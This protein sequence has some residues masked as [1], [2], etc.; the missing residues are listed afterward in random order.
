MVSQ[1]LELSDPVMSLLTN[2][3]STAAGGSLLLLPVHVDV[4]GVGQYREAHLIIPKELRH[5]DVPAEFV[6][7]GG[8]RIGLS[9]YSSEDLVVAFAF[10]VVQN[11]TW[12]AAKTA[13]SYLFARAR[14][15]ATDTEPLMEMKIAR[16]SRPDGLLIEGVTITGPTDDETAAE[17]VRALVGDHPRLP[18]V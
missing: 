15:Y 6:Q 8:Q 17:L 7:D 10:G 18:P 2:R 16:V 11:M 13:V 12:D 14:Q 9:E 1:A 3:A 4:N 5:L